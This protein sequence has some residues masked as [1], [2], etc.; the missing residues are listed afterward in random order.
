MAAI[1]IVNTYLR[2][3]YLCS[4]LTLYLFTE[5]TQKQRVVPF[6]TAFSHSSLLTQMGGCMK[7]K[8]PGEVLCTF[9]GG[10][11]SLGPLDPYPIPDQSCILQLILN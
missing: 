8:N 3:A 1:N 9:M 2:L 7:S 11:V 4:V 5:C 6:F 10:D